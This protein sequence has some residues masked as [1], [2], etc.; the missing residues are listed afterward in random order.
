MFGL[1]VSIFLFENDFRLASATQKSDSYKLIKF[2]V[3]T[4][5]YSSAWENEAEIEGIFRQH[6]EF[7]NIVNQKV[8]NDTAYITLKTNISARERFLELADQIT[9][10][11]TDNAASQSPFGKTIRSML[12]LSKNYW[13]NHSTYTFGMQQTFLNKMACYHYRQIFL[14]SPSPVV[15]S[16]PPQ[17]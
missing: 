17:S 5:P 12:N 15:F 10:G 14:K 16:P 4:L 2:P 13:Q 8:E 6:S 1:A 11:T 7:Y 9:S 3:L